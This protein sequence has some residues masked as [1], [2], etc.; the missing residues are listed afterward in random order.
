MPSRGRERVGR[1]TSSACKSASR[2]TKANIKSVLILQPQDLK[3]VIDMRTAIDLVEQGYGEATAFPLINAPR[4]RVHSRKNVRVSSFPGGIDGLSVIGSLT[5]A[6]SLAHDEKSQVFPY[7]E[8]PVYLLWNSETS[9]HEAIMIGEILEKTI[10][11]S[12]I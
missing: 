5:R 10:C 6:E 2:M 8:H 3:V 1:S 11:F 4:R 9:A 12:G 7:R